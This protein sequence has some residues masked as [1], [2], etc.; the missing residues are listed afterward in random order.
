[1][2]VF[3]V[4]NSRDAL[5]RFLWLWLPVS[6]LFLKI[7]A[8]LYL[9]HEHIEWIVGENGPYEMF[10]AG[11]IILALMIALYT[12]FKMPKGN[13]WLVGWISTVALFCFYVAGEEI[14]WGQHILNW[15]TPE[16]WQALNDQGETNLHNTTSWLDQKTRLI[17]STGVYLGG[18]II[19]LM[20]LL[21]SKFLEQ[22]LVKRFEIVYPTPQ[23]MVVSMICLFIKIADKLAD[24]VDLHLFSRN[25]ESEEIFLF[26]FVFLYLLLMKKRLVS[27]KTEA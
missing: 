4:S 26:Y 22:S 27:A 23:F 3:S 12:L 9:E 8:E 10:G 24:V 18:L 2:S 5:L 1:M 15:S 17:L 7:G 16:H 11:V 13:K 6:I 21:K 25:A 20:I 14:I 19:P